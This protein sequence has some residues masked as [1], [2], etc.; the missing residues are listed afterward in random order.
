MALAQRKPGAGLLH[1]SDRGGQYASSDYQQM[2]RD[3]GIVC[4]MSRKGNCWDNAPTESFFATSNE[5]RP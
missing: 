5:A 1:H 3:A 4:S 2:L